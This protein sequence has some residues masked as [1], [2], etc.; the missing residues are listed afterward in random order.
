MLNLG[1]H[2]VKHIL[3]V[4]SLDPYDN[5]IRQLLLEVRKLRC[6]VTYQV[7]RYRDAKPGPTAKARISRE[8][9]CFEGM[10]PRR[11][12]VE[13]KT[14]FSWSTPEWFIVLWANVFLDFLQS[15]EQYSLGE[16][17]RLPPLQAALSQPA[18]M[19]WCRSNPDT[20][21][22]CSLPLCLRPHN[23]SSLELL[24]LPLANPRHIPL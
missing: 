19:C 5:P 3:Q 1:Q 9:H 21:A 16:G 11:L 20:K 13:P 15:F 6:K 12:S 4:I 18:I 22:D 24:L 7:G 2:C 17:D 23:E 10:R 14:H 8:L